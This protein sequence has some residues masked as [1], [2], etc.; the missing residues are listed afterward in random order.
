ML[1]CHN[2]CLLLS[3]AFSALP[4]CHA[5]VLAAQGQPA[6]GLANHQQLGRIEELLKKVDEELQDV[7]KEQRAMKKEQQEMKNEQQ[8]IKTQLQGIKEEQQQMQRNISN[9]FHRSAP[10]L[11]A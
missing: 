3:H 1:S 10:E 6:H 8:E 9:L 7:K 4:V 11:H 5:G 2:A